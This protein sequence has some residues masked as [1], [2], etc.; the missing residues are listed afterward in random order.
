M[1]KEK[2]IVI[3]AVGKRSLPKAKALALQNKG[4]VELYAYEIK[5]HFVGNLMVKHSAN[6][7]WMERTKVE[8]LIDGF[9]IGP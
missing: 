1:A 2:E 5:D 9:K 6:A 7:S 4:E 8:K 3:K